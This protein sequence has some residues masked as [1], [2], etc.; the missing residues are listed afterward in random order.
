MS[1]SGNACR[2]GAVLGMLVASAA[3]L[4]AQPAGRPNILVVV[5]DDLGYSD[6]GAFGGEISTPTLDGLAAQGTLL[7]SFYTAPF[8]SPTRAMLMTGTDNHQA[9]FGAMTELIPPEIREN[10]GYEGFLNDHALAFPQL[11]QQDGYRTY[12]TGKWH[13]GTTPE[14]SPAMRGFDHSYALVQGGA[15]HFDQTGIIAVDPAVRPKALYREDGQEVDLPQDF[16]SSQFFVDRMIDYLEADKDSD[17]P[18]FAYLG[19]TAPH[20]PLQARAEDIAKYDGAYAD[21]YDALRARRVSAMKDKSI[22]PAGAEVYPGNPA[23][24]HWDTLAPHIQKAEARRMAVYAAMVD[25]MDRELGR[26]IDYLDASGDLDNT[27]IV[28]LSDN[29]ADGNTAADVARTR[30]WIEQTFDNS[31]ENTGMPDS[32][33][34]YGPGWAQVGSTPLRHFKAFLYEGGIRAPAFAVLPKSQRSGRGGVSAAFTHVMDVAPTILDIAGVAP[35]GDSFGGQPVHPMQGASMLPF[36]RG[37]ADAVHGPDHVTGWELQG[38]KALRKGNWK[39]VYANPPWG[40]DRWELFDLSKDPSE[41]TDLS[42][43]MPDKVAE[44]DAEYQV[45]AARNGV[46]DLTGLG[47]T[48]GYSNGMEYYNDIP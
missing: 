47:R 25:S 8:C 19:F 27:F 15:G 29:G 6:L 26:L 43:Q 34:D 10:P 7:T 20:W 46:L 16:Y 5:A 30:E 41:M 11:L 21:G 12:L 4:F 17:Q 1:L 23:W 24:P 22:I 28:F 38:R 39:I 2:L 32:Y 33:I 14:R 35:A 45:W 36:L 40:T 9:G 44:L 48:V 3:P 42:A 31:V 13:L 37:E 18:F